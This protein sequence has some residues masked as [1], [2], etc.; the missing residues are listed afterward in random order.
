MGTLATA[1]KGSLVYGP[2]I[3]LYRG[4]VPLSLLLY[5]IAKETGFYRLGV[6]IDK[7]LIEVGLSQVPLMRAWELDCDPF[8]ARGACWL[9]CI[10]ALHDAAHWR[11]EGSEDPLHQKIGEWLVKADRNLWWVVQM[12]YSVGTGALEYILAG[13][14]A[15]AENAER[16]PDERGLMIE[17]I[18][19]A[20]TTTLSEPFHQRHWGRQSPE[21]IMARILKHRDWIAGASKL[22]P[23]DDAPAGGRAPLARP[24]GVA[25]FP[26]SLL[27][28]AKVCARASSPEE[29]LR[30]W[31]FV[32][33]YAKERARI[34]IAPKAP[35]LFRVA[36]WFE[37]EEAREPVV[38]AA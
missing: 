6:S 34:E 28:A 24:Q 2:T 15:R 13:A 27:S 25:P 9:A 10:E 37:R 33:R 22:G 14:I 8:D 26:T 19:W 1:R 16:G 36:K 3:D 12:D 4:F 11:A 5:W 20:A 17:A 30:A 31:N 18:D 21:Q 29:R 23:L 32:R 7:K 38:R 35:R